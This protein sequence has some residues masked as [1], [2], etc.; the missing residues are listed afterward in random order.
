M[1][2]ADSEAVSVTAGDEDGKTVVGELDAGGHGEGASVERVHAVGVD[3]AGEVGGASDA[4]DGADLM[5]GNLQLD[6]G[7]LHG[8][9]D[10]EIAASGTPVRINFAL[11]VRHR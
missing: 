9:E 2:A 11:Q 3:V 6:Q 4:A 5:V 10:A 8:G 7:F 1:I